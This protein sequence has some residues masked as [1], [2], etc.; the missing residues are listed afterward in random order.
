[1]VLETIESSDIPQL[2]DNMII[3]SP[4]LDKSRIIFSGQNNVAFFEDGVTLS[5]STIRFNGSG[6]LAMFGKSRHA[7]KANVTINNNC[8]VVFG[9]DIYFN[10][11]L[12][13]ITSE[14]TTIAIGSGTLLSFGIWM[15]TADPHL[16][17]D[18]DTH[19]RINPS[20]H[21]VVGDHVWIGQSAMVLKGTTIGSGSILGAMSL[22]SGKKLPSNTSWG[23][24]PSRQ[25]RD[26]VFWEGSCVHTWTGQK[27]A[28]SQT[29]LSDEFIYAEDASTLT[30]ERFVAQSNLPARDRLEHYL[31][32]GYDSEQHN[33]LAI[34]TR[35]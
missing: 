34:N 21:I 13:A 8:S 20:K 31:R 30:P 19:T 5:S 33:R 18:M 23:G 10:G 2:K 32:I 4:K 28:Q 11:T 17:Y 9:R 29:M 35:L 24:N 14:E 7:Y 12:N 26:R 22:V 15:R 25:I 1:M 6:G 16:I 3:G 27:T